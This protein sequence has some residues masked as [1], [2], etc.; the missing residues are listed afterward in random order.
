MQ[1]VS[2]VSTFVERI[3]K[4]ARLYSPAKK[5][6]HLYFALKL[7]NKINGSNYNA[8]FYLLRKI[9]EPKKGLKKKQL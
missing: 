8:I 4:L 1:T 6:S 7:T 5:S 9:I 2:F 3:V